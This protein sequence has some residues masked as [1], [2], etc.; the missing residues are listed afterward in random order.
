MTLN[1][2]YKISNNFKKNILLK[3]DQNK[4]IKNVNYLKKTI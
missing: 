1:L 2:K 3:K 4:K